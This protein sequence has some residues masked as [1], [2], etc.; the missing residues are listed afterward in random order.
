MLDGILDKLLKMVV[1]QISPELRALLVEWIKKL[2][3]QA[4]QT[5]SPYDNVL[6]YLLK[7]LLAIND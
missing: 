6:I 7:K 4:E 5:S 2:E 3:E 1:E